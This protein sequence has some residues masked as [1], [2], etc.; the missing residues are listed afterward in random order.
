MSDQQYHQIYELA[1][2]GVVL[3]CLILLALIRLLLDR[4]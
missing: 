3:L 2:W 4:R 1:I